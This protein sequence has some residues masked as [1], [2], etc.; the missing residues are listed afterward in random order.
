VPGYANPQNLNRYSYV[1][2]NPL[3]YTD[4]TGHR[5][6]ENYQGRCLSENQVTNWAIGRTNDDYGH[7][8]ISKTRQYALNITGIVGVLPGGL[9]GEWAFPVSFV[10]GLAN[11]L[12][13]ATGLPN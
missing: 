2:N 6:C 1:T 3:R 11:L 4:P 12:I 13:T 10:S 7:G 8:K 5:Q 9:L